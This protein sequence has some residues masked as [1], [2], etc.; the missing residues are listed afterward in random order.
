[1]PHF[2]VKSFSL[3]VFN[4]RNELGALRSITLSGEE[5]QR[6]QLWFLAGEPRPRVQLNE[7][8]AW[9]AIFPVMQYDAILELLRQP[10]PVEVSFTPP[11]DAAITSVAAP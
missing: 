4:K 6:A 10:A 2:R 9:E 5:A 1:M 8:G 11:Q 3:A 7:D